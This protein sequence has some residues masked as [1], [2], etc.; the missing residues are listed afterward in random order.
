MEG[1]VTNTATVRV[2]LSKEIVVEC[3]IDHALGILNRRRT[4]LGAQVLHEAL[5]KGNTSLERSI[6]S[7]EEHMNQ[8]NAM[9]KSIEVKQSYSD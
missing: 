3:S 6:K 2:A 4:E 5:L 8:L 1:V 9:C 7:R